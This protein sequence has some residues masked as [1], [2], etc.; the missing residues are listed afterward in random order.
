MRLDWGATDGRY[1]WGG[2]IAGVD[3]QEL[4]GAALDRGGGAIGACGVGGMRAVGV[5]SGVGVDEHAF[6]SELL[7]DVDLDAAVGFAVADEDDLAFDGDAELGE[8]LE[9]G[10]ASVVGIDD[11]SGDVGCGRGVVE[12]L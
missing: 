6:G 12:G 2:G 8:V 11:G 9:V 4:D 1:A 3:G 10:K 5:V 7:G